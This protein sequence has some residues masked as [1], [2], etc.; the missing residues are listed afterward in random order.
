MSNAQAPNYTY[1]DGRG[2]THSVSPQYVTTLSDGRVKAN[3][4]PGI[5]GHTDGRGNMEIVDRKRG[6]TTTVPMS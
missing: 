6:T 4:G 1:V 2:K 5:I 3:Y